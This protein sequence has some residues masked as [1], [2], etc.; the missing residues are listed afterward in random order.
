MEGGNPVEKTGRFS[1]PTFF[2]FLL[3]SVSSSAIDILLF[4]LLV[5][6][7]KA[8]TPV[9]ILFSTVGARLV[10][11]LVNFT[12]NRRRVFRGSGNRRRTLARFALLCVCVMTASA[13]LV[14]RLVKLLGWEETMVK[15]MV[16]GLLFF[17]NYTVQR[18]W[19]FRPDGRGG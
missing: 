3:S 8:L 1:I 13:F 2:R 11:S 17:V 12:I 9:Y 19:V 7:L 15:M 10:S 16:D 5:R 6:L 4:H 18:K 14:G